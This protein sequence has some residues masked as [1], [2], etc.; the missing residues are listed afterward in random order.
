MKTHLNEK[1]LNGMYESN[2]NFRTIFHELSNMP[3][4]DE[5]VIDA[6]CAK[7][8]KIGKTIP[9]ADIVTFF[10]N[11]DEFG[12]GQYIVGRKGHPSRFRWGA[13]SVTIGTPALPAAIPAASIPSPYTD[14][15]GT[16]DIP[17][18]EAPTVL[19]RHKY[20]LRP[21]LVITLELPT[22]ISTTEATRIGQFVALLA[23]TEKEQRNGRTT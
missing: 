7:L 11:L 15:N 23:H 12:A 19:I 3:R 20:H 4:Q 17:L 16:H 1:A 6:L 18:G 14:S 22:D 10:R 5:T 8:G 9:H 21:H 2:G 13:D